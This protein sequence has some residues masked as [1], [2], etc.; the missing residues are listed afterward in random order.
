MEPVAS[1]DFQISALTQ[2]TAE[3]DLD[4]FNQLVLSIRSLHL[5]EP[6]EMIRRLKMQHRK[7]LSKHSKT[8]VIS[9]AD[10]SMHGCSKS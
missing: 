8:G 10:P 1:C 5:A 4:A 9:E 3:A 7:A 2:K 6:T